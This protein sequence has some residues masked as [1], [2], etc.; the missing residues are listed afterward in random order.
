MAHCLIRDD[1]TGIPAAVN[2]QQ[3]SFRL[4]VLRAGPESYYLGG[5]LSPVVSFGRAVPA[6]EYRHRVELEHGEP[7]PGRDW[8]HIRVRQTDGQCAWSSRSGSNPRRPG[9]PSVTA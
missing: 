4:G 1:A 9:E 2:G 7:G 8:Y 6:V 3:V 5:F